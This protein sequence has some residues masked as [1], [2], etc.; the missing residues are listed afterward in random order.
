MAPGSAGRF[1]LGGKYENSY[2]RGVRP[3]GRMRDGRLWSK[4]LAM[5]IFTVLAGCL[6]LGGCLT[7]RESDLIAWQGQP[8]EAL[9]KQPFF[10]TLQM[11]RSF[12]ADGTEIRNYVNGRT[13]S[14]CSSSATTYGTS[15]IATANSDC[16]SQFS[17]C[18]NIFYIKNGRVIRYTPVGSGGAKCM[19]DDRVLPI[20]L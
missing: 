15:T 3:A 16:T 7:V 2:C 4:F 20:R 19:T 5:K 11:Q 10:L 6:F 9:D 8:V 12:A 14:S 13:S 18:N 1:I 17:A